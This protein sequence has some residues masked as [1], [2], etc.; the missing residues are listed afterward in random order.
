MP[1][2]RSHQFQS[3]PTKED[4]RIGQPSSPHAPERP[5]Q[6][7]KVKADTN[8]FG[9]S[10]EDKN[11]VG[12]EEDTKSR[13]RTDTES[14]DEMLQRLSAE[15]DAELQEVDML[16]GKLDTELQEVCRHGRRCDARRIATTKLLFQ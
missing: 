5:E 13:V 6:I 9:I 8:R 12:W 16:S 4:Q 2:I 15:L 10:K 11:S 1:E 14:I 3:N 7:N